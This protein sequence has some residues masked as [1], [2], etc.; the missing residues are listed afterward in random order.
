MLLF[1]LLASHTTLEHASSILISNVLRVVS[2]A[3]LNT[4]LVLLSLL[5]SHVD[6]LHKVAGV[7]L[8]NRQF[9]VKHTELLSRLKES[10]RELTDVSQSIK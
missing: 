5:A 1:L 10:S 7:D 6:I 9:R 4:I 2:H 3:L 8:V